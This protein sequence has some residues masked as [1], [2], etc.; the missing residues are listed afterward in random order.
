[1][2]DEGLTERLRQSFR[3]Q[4][5]EAPGKPFLKELEEFFVNYHELKGKKYRILKCEGRGRHEDESKKRRNNDAQMRPKSTRTMMMRRT[6]PR[7]P[8]G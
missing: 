3:K 6:R 1:M 2:F 4:K 5:E 8:E 7:P